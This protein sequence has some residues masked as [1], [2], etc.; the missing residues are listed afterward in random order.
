MSGLRGYAPYEPNEATQ[1]LLVQVQSLLDVNNAYL[2]VSLRQL[3]Y[4]GVSAYQWPKTEKFYKGLCAKI[5][6]ARRARII[7]FEDIRD[8]GITEEKPNVWQSEN[9]L[10]S[11]IRDTVDAV[12][13]DHMQHQERDVVIWTEGRGLVPMVQQFTRDFYVPVITSGGFDGVTLKREFAERFRS[14]REAIV[15]H[16]GDY[17]PS[18]EVMFRALAE[19]VEAFGGN[20]EYRRIAV[21]DEHIDYYNLPTKPPKRGKNTHALSFDDNR[22]VELEAM[23]P[24]DLETLLR[25]ALRGVLDMSVV[26]RAEQD[27]NDIRDRLNNRLGLT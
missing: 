6:R 7:D 18:G 17:D 23:P 27:S 19:D 25:D 26:R 3:F 14:S 4:L 11:A 16:V 5:T 9:S 21:L 22:T 10:L 20:V 8:D 15:L 1:G 24:A 2:P 13:I 12:M